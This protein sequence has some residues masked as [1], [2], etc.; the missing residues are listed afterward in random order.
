V[1]WILRVIL[2]FALLLGSGAG[3]WVQVTVPAQES[4]CGA[5]ASGEDACPCPKPE[6]NRSPSQSPCPSGVTTVAA[7]SVRQAER[8]RRTEPRPEPTGWAEATPSHLTLAASVVDGGRDPDLGRHLA[9]LS[10]HRI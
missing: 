2:A 3:D 4:C 1:R 5:P 9:R 10:T 6:G 8:T 7:Q